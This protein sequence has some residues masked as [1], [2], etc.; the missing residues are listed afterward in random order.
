MAPG[1]FKATLREGCGQ[2]AVTILQTGC[3]P[4]T[5]DTRTLIREANGRTGWWRSVNENEGPPNTGDRRATL[6]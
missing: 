4:N 6:E 3:G 5:G 1:N 2:Q